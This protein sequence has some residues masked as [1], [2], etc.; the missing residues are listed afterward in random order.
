MKNKYLLT[1]FIILLISFGNHIYSQCPGCVIDTTCS[2]PNDFGLCP[3]DTINVIAFQDTF[4]DITFKVPLQY[5]DSATSITVNVFSIEILAVNG[6]P[7]GLDWECNLSPTC[8]YPGG[9]M[10]CIR[11][12]GIP[13]SAPGIYIA[14][15]DL[16]AE[17][18]IVGSQT[19]SFEVIFQVLQSGSNN[20]GF[21]FSPAFACDSVHVEF[22]ALLENS[23]FPI[24]YQWDF[25]NGNS[26]TLQF[27]ET[28]LYSQPDTYQVILQT[29]LIDYVI[30]D[31]TANSQGNWY[32]GDVEELWTWI[33][34]PDLFF[35]LEHGAGLYTSSTIDDDLTAHWTGL[36]I[37][38]A[39]TNI[40]LNFWDEDFGPP[41]GSSDDDG[42]ISQ[43]NISGAGVYN[44]STTGGKV[45]G[46]VTVEEQIGLVFSDTDMVVVYPSPT[47]VDIDVYPSQEVC[48]GEQ[49]ILNSNVEEGLQWFFNGSIMSGI[50]TSMLETSVS[51]IYNLVA[52]N[53]YGCTNQSDT[54]S[55]VFHPL[56]PP[57]FFWI[58]YDTLQTNLTG[59]D[60]QWYFYENEL[61]EEI[62]GAN[63]LIYVAD[64]SGYYFV[65]ATSGFGCISSSDT[66]FVTSYSMI[67]GKELTNGLK[68]YPNPAQE[69]IS[70][71]FENIAEVEKMKIIDSF[72]KI[73]FDENLDLFQT[74]FLRKI[75]IKN[76]PAGIY[77]IQLSSSENTESYK[78]IIN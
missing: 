64:E 1:F 2:P 43:L 9:G 44:Y 42:G 8:E 69:F 66:V 67:E 20:N 19:I 22:E 54:I 24:S 71:E 13:Q 28:Q 60:L 27:P 35:V 32:A 47:E 5:T 26:D 61:S 7:S 49:I 53:N 16:N 33:G 62:I 36:N 48:E 73:L 30:V 75:N 50:D 70:I 40:I 21:S 74:Y 78:F 63:D 6:V 51:G 59:Y 65:L 52:T 4:I 23:P 68:I 38:L 11:I 57:P 34:D 46:T 77:C 12:C 17:V 18:S 56:P 41:L 76:F 45:S 10:G 39:D 58:I 25:G 15:V 55:L 3:D 31:V 37:V 29:T 72:G 14:T